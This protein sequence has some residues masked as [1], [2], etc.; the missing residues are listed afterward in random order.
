MSKGTGFRGVIGFL[1]DREGRSTQ[2]G[3]GAVQVGKTNGGIGGRN[4]QQAHRSRF[5]PFHNFPGGP[6]R[7]WGN[8]TRG[9]VPKILHFGPVLGIGHGAI[10]RQQPRQTAGLA[11][12]HGVGL[13]SQGKGPRAR[14]AHLPRQQVQVNDAANFGCAFGGLV[15]AHGPKG[16][17]P[18]ALGPNSR[19]CLDRLHRNAALLG[20]AIGRVMLQQIFVGCEAARVGFDIGA[21]DLIPLQQQ[22]GHAVQ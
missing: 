19:R 22:V 11:A 10:A 4:P 17:D 20:H 8:A 21:I 13:A 16:Q 6:A 1:I 7:C 15:N 9:Q 18:I 5:Q 12:A 14:F 2:G 3:F